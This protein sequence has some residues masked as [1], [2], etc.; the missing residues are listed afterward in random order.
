MHSDYPAEW[1]RAERKGGIV[2]RQCR[3]FE[4]RNARVGDHAGLQR[5][6]QQREDDIERFDGDMR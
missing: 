1:S 3:S 5:I 2:A 6:G 4:C